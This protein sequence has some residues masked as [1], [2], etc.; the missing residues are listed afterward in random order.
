MQ[1]HFFVYRYTLQIWIYF[2][3]NLAQ[4]EW[5]EEYKS[6]LTTSSFATP[7]AMSRTSNS[8]YAESDDVTT[9]LL[10][11][12]VRIMMLS[13]MGYYW[14]NVKCFSEKEDKQWNKRQ[15]GTESMEHLSSERESANVEVLKSVL[16]LIIELK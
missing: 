13:I 5:M 10:K 4:K 1:L 2:N 11:L 15:R 3:K 6:N 9:V 16:D 12:N 8:S 7:S 14:M